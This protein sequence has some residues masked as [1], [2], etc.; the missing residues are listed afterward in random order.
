MSF[1]QQAKSPS[2]QVKLTA[3]TMKCFQK[4]CMCEKFV[5]NRNKKKKVS[6]QRKSRLHSSCL[7]FFKV[8]HRFYL[9]N[10]LEVLQ[11]AAHIM[12]IWLKIM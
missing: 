10:A 7:S 5:V 3:K 1:T 9:T 2:E 11:L 12:T 8:K 4:N 6:R